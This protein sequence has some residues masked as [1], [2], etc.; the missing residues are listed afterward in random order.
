MHSLKNLFFNFLGKGISA[1]LALFFTP[2][3]LR[4]LGAENFAIIGIYYSLMAVFSLFD[5]GFSTGL[6]R[7]LSRNPNSKEN[8]KLFKNLEF[9]FLIFSLLLLLIYFL[10]SKFIIVH[11]FSKNLKIILDLHFSFFLVGICLFFHLPYFFYNNVLVGLQKQ[12]ALNLVIVVISFLKG[13]GILLLFNIFKPSLIYFFYWQIFL[14]FLQTVLLKLIIDKSFKIKISYKLF[15][16]LKV[17]QNSQFS[18]I[19]NFSLQ[20]FIISLAHLFLTQLDKFFV[21]KFV[22]LKELGLYSFS[23][24]VA[25]GLQYLIGPFFI[26]F[27]PKFSELV[28]KKKRIQLIEEYHFSTKLIAMLLIPIAIIFLFFS[29]EISYLLTNNVA[30]ASEISMMLKSFIIAMCIHGLMNIVFALQYAYGYSKLMFF[31]NISLVVVMFPLMYFLIKN[32]GVVGASFFSLFVNFS[33]LFINVFYLLH[34][35]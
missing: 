27:F 3:Y 25:A 22:T 6:S 7:E 10:F 26:A 24:N 31:H 20:F 30:Y 1:F 14:C 17:F 29:K 9:L 35:G 18:K 11:F 4:Y 16:I 28:K 33:Y 15:E 2:M 5:F 21:G 32:Y 23:F 34:F 19:L 8:L 12:K 13:F